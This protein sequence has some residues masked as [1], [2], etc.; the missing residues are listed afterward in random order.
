MIRVSA[1]LGYVILCAGCG[2][3]PRFDAQSV[4]ETIKKGRTAGFV[5]MD[6][7]DTRYYVAGL[8]ALLAEAIKQRRDVDLAARE[9]SFYSS[10]IALG[11]AIADSKAAVNTGTGGALLSELFQGRHRLPDQKQAFV[12]A[13]NKL[14]CIRQTLAPINP[15]YARILKEEAQ[16][17][18]MVGEYHMI[19][20]RTLAA[21]HSIDQQLDNTLADV[22][23]TTMTFEQIA[24]TYSDALTAREVANETIKPPV[25]DGE[26]NAEAL[27]AF[28]E[29]AE[30][31]KAKQKNPH[32]CSLNKNRKAVA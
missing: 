7:R 23:A 22:A 2:H 29:E 21:I 3:L 16:F 8:E 30:V 27:N 31:L 24:R 25:I 15:A 10:I 20:T 9:V 19:P 4:E 11:G 17:Q 13:R 26:V 1:L 28:N 32:P 18:A 5:D 12:A 6:V 14:R